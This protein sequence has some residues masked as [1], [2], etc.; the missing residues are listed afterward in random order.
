MRR[1]AVAISAV[2][3]SHDRP[4]RVQ[5]YVA[6]IAVMTSAATSATNSGRHAT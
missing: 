1:R 3:S 6:D 5:S 2:R 4:T